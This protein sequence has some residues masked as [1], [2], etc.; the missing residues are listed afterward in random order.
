MQRVT[1]VGAGIGGLAASLALSALDVEVLLVERAARPTEVGAALALQANGL[2]VLDRLGLLDEV[3]RVGA[4]IDDLVTRD[5]AGRV[6]MRARSPDLGRG[7][8]HAVAVHRGVLHS[9]LLDA[10]AAC[11]QVTTRFGCAVVEADPTGTVTLTLPSGAPETVRAD[12]VIG[13]DGV[14]SRVRA[15]G[16]FVSRV[17]PGTRYV[18]TIVDRDVGASF[19]EHWTALGSF[20]LGPLGAGRTYFWVAAH[21]GAAAE[22]VS[23]EDLAGLAAAW[24]PVAPLAGELLAAVDRFDDLLINTVRRVDCR[25]WFSGRLV[26]LGDAAH[27]MAPNLGQG[28]NSAL[29]DAVLLT[30]QL[31]VGASVPAALAAYDGLRRPIV[32]RI[33]DGAGIL[34]RLCGL[35]PG[36]GRVLRDA[37]FRAVARSE[38]LTERGLRRAL[39]PD[40]RAVRTAAPGLHRPGASR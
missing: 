34:Q 39:L 5:A 20:G 28:A 19:E 32:R 8:D 35:G 38:R 4:R 31:A 21:R 27:G 13:A 16:G 6:L 24:R 18:R 1:V 33:Q 10:V 7:L 37:A 11:P 29:V 26:L 15:S 23:Q 30:E 12:V 3:A 17:S 25:R 9:I 14:S 22:A 40:V 36:P 2:A